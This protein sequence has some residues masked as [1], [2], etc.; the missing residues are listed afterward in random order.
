MTI[1]T[2]REKND[3]VKYELEHKGTEAGTGWFAPMP[4]GQVDF[5]DGLDYMREH[6][7]DD[8]L[9]RYM[10]NQIGTFGPNLAGQL[11]ERGLEG[12]PHLAA[13]MYEACFLMERFRHLTGKFD[14]QDMAGL[15]EHTPLIYIRWALNKA[16]EDRPKNNEDWLTLFAENIIKHHSLTPPTD[17]TSAIPFSQEA[18]DKWK[19]GAVSIARIHGRKNGGITGGGG[20]GRTAEET[21]RFATERLKAIEIQISSENANP[22]S[23]N[24]LGLQ[25]KWHMEV[26][27]STGRHSH[28]LS[29]LQT[30]YGKGLTRQDARA[31]CLMEVCERV[32]SFAGF[33]SDSTV[34]YKQ[35]HA[36][37]HGGLEDL[38]GQDISALDPNT[39]HLEIPYENQPLY[40]IPAEQVVAQG[41][42]PIH[43]PAQ[44]VFL[45]CNL[46]ET[47]LS[48][49]M[50]STG[51]ASGN[52]LEEAKLSALLEVIE[53]DSERVMPFLSERCFTL[54]ATDPLVGEVLDQTRNEGLQVRFL[55]ITTELGIPCYKA[56]IENPNGEVLKGAAAHLD[57]KRAAVSALLEVP[58]H[59]S[60]F[61]QKPG[62]TDGKVYQIDDLPNYS[63]GNAGQDL[64]LLE[65]LLMENGHHP[66][67]VDLTREDLDI[68]VVKALVTGL[69]FFPEF[70]RF[71]S[72]S[73]RQ[74]G[75]YLNA[76]S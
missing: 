6:P 3:L 26:S 28:Q 52:T 66:I 68:P 29:G 59:A 1:E 47:C 41:T 51:L 7:N 37:I 46:D 38:K 67:Y 11:I 15:A 72:L 4:V 9:H 42:Q 13:L 50:P 14:G 71:S 48:D 40:W 23:I 73:L 39:M 19:R 10:L 8:F 17:M 32:S 58:Y 65:Q 53:R 63:T 16:P 69:E 21:S 76:F 12:E 24:P 49:G 62:P 2:A 56:F 33:E 70:D 25:M 36:L 75:H 61:R 45:F 54:E 74:F 22:A 35:G 31:S 55:D 43:V 27:V 44:L 30:S 57:G 18:L 60:W 5:E 20:P 34:G 64:A